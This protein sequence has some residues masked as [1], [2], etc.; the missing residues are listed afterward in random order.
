MGVGLEELERVYRERYPRFHRLARALTADDEQAFDA[1]QET[2]A[3]AIRG[4]RGFRRQATVET[5]LWRTLVNVCRD[6]RRRS[7][8]RP[9]TLHA[10]ELP[11]VPAAGNGHAEEWPELRAAI[12]A[13]PERQRLILFLAHYADL[14]QETIAAVAGIARGTVAATLHHAHSSLRRALTEVPT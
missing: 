12:G 13:L 14:D 1:V 11:D 4:R 2:F 3:R 9:I 5:W 7:V 8:A 10:D 6:E